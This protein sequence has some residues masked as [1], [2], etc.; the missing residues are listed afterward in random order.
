MSL[1]RFGTFFCTLNIGPFLNILDVNVEFRC[2][3]VGVGPN[4]LP[5]SCGWP[6]LVENIKLF[7]KP[8]EAQC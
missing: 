1:F 8:S 2:W 6:F 7:M 4:E 3:G 5:S